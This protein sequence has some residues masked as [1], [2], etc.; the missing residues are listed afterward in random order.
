MDGHENIDLAD[1]HGQASLTARNNALPHDVRRKSSTPMLAH[2]RK[3]SRLREQYSDQYLDLF[4]NT[5]EVEDQEYSVDDF[6]SFQLGAV[7][8][9]P[10]D[11]LRFFDAISRK[12]QHDLRAISK[13]VESKS[14]IEVKAY[15]DY[16]REQQT[17]RQ[18]YEAQ[19]K[20][21]SHA[22]IPA[23]F[24]IGRDCEVVLDQTAEALAAFQEQFDF[25][26]GQRMNPLWLIDAATASEL[27]QS[28][29][30]QEVASDT[31]EKATETNITLSVEACRFFHLSTFL[32]LSERFFINQSASQAN[33]R[34]QHVEDDQG[35]AMTIEVVL[36][37]HNLVT[38]FTRRL[39]QTCIFLA[40]SRLRSLG[41]N[42]YKHGGL[43]KHE[44]VSAALA[45]LGVKS[46]S[47]DY[48][49]RLARRNRLSVVD[50]GHRKGSS[51]KAA[52]PY[53]EVEERLSNPRRGRSRSVES[54]VSSAD[55]LASEDSDD[56][57]G[58][59]HSDDEAY[60]EDEE[61]SSEGS[62]SDEV[63]DDES[64]TVR[65]DGYEL[66]PLVEK[67]SSIPLSKKQK[68]EVLE[69][70]QDEYMERLDR[71]AGRQE[72]ARLLQSLGLPVEKEPKEEEFEL[73]HRPKVLRKSVEECMGWSGVYQAE[74]ELE[75][76]V[77]PA[78]AF[79][80]VGS[81]RKRRKLGHES[82]EG[83]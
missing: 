69:Q 34:H 12:G 20:N 62:R 9:A 64:D 81:R 24:E 78:E 15:I 55:S 47:A 2:E 74:W 39:V 23:A 51:T 21:V 70:E 37:Y 66:D 18:L 30:E 79:A 19:T 72:E 61:Q 56:G 40:M 63:D 50:G 17:D 10:A 49:V 27:D 54:Q 43:V 28:T 29:N 31:S 33:T 52:M 77:V 76:G 57:K 46:S 35:P 4:K 65:R 45:V 68:I 44:D 71:E 16:L 13:A 38:S 82:L 36:D 83:I 48:W 58:D 59:S 67:S 53:D 42:H 80:E 14:E 7:T 6:D 73:G 5:F 75:G 25:A 3:W 26:V 1:N 11:K 41:S 8:W 60:E 32:T 22:E